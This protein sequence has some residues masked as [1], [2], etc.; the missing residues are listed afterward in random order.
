MVL[1]IPLGPAHL[2]ESIVDAQTVA[3]PD[4]IQVTIKDL[5]AIDR[6]IETQPDIVVEKPRR[7]GIGPGRNALDVTCHWICRTAA[8]SFGI[9]Q[10]RHEIAHRC[11]ADRRDIGVACGVV[12]L[13]DPALLEGRAVLK[14]N[15]VGVGR[16]GTGRTSTRST[17]GPGGCRHQDRR[18]GHRLTLGQRCLG[19][20]SI[21]RAVVS[22][23]AFGR[24][25]VID[26]VLVHR[27]GDG[28]SVRIL[29]Q[30]QDGLDQV[31]C[32]GTHRLGI[33]T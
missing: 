12:Q 8:V 25:V 23:R 28:R 33:P 13:V 30:R 26:D 15:R 17:P 16:G 5:G 29:G 22:R 32:G 4:V 10:E 7:L 19:G 20:V 27:A 31:H 6:L 1:P 14:G 2:G 24:G 11:K 18:I 3:A 21:G 9:A